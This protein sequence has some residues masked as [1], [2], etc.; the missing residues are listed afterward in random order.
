[1]TSGYEVHDRSILVPP[2]K[3][4]VWGPLLPLI[5]EHVSANSLTLLGTGMSAAAF[6]ITVFIAPTRL[7][8]VVIAMLVFGYLCL[9]NVDGAH[10]RRTGTSSPLGEFLDH[11][12]DALNLSFLFMGCVHT[13]QIPD[14][15]AVAIMVLAVLSY[16][17][18]F[19]EQRVTGRIHMGLL[20]NV[21]GIVV[22]VLFYLAAAV[23]GVQTLIDNELFA[24]QTI[25]DFFWY[26]AIVNTAVTS[27][28]PL[29]RV[30]KDFTHVIEVVVPVAGLG[31]WYAAGHVSAPHVCS[32]LMLMSPALA[33]RMLIAR[34]TG[35]E[36][37]GPDRFLLMS[38]LVAA[39]ASIA[40]QLAAGPQMVM[41]TL[42]T[43]YATVLVTL[44]FV[45]TVRRLGD[46][47]R[48]GELLA[49]ARLWP[50]G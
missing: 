21:E 20:G 10:A 25:I 14:D 15:R 7:S 41:L 43:L 29:L 22:V 5:P 33:G 28:G 13:F 36:N 50:P 2:L 45:L 32:I 49:F 1:M 37:L 24:G 39:F 6:A 19:W 35:Q 34:V 3:R 12:L 17:M 26:S 42:I 16:T 4:F 27:L 23:F 44:D 11:W 38:I 46:Y 47:L 31:L 48:P 40:F 8:C 30:R 9:D 18:T